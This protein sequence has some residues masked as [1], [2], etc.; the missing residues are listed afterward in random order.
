MSDSLSGQ[1]NEVD[2]ENLFVFRQQEGGANREVDALRSNPYS[3]DFQ[4]QSN[5][6]INPQLGDGRPNESTPRRNIPQH[7]QIRIQRSRIINSEREAD[8]R[9]GILGDVDV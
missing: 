1:S 9:A 3:N 6:I 2:E 7:G 5:R 4:R 8:G